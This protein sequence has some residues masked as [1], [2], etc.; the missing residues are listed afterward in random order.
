MH[1]ILRQFAA[2]L[3][4]LQLSSLLLAA[5]P[6]QLT[7]LFPAGGQ[8]GTSVEV[9]ATGKF[10]TWPAKI[11][12]DSPHIE[13]SCLAEAGKLQAKISDQAPAGLQWVRLYDA[14]G[15]TQV[16]PFLID[17]YPQAS[18]T[19]PNDRNDTANAS[20]GLPS[21]FHGV[22]NKTADVDLISVTLA[23]DDWLVATLDSAKW[24]LSPA[25]AC[26]QI[27]DSRGFVL[28]ENLDHVG[29]DPY[30]EYQAPRAGKYFV[31][32]FGFPATPNSTIAFSGG[33]DWIYRLR[34]SDRPDPL[35]TALDIAN[36]KEVSSSCAEIPAAKHTA[37][38]R[39][40]ALSLPAQVTGTVSQP[41]EINY[42]RFTAQAGKTYRVRL[43]ARHFGSPLDASLAILDASGKQL[44]QQDDVAQ[45]RDPLVNWKAPADGDFV[46]AIR[47]FHRQGGAG[48]RYQLKLEE[49]TPDYAAT[50][51]TDLITA[52]VDKEVEV[53]VN[54][55]RELDF[56][57]TI[58]VS[59]KGVPDFVQAPSVESKHGTDTAGKVSLK[60]KASQAFQGPIEILATSTAEPNPE[61][62]AATAGNRPLWLS[63]R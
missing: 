59:L 55:A 9:T 38:D 50:L 19:E 56:P 26:L 2:S 14:A 33:S 53:V 54:I 23:D 18:E 49:R 25:D 34:L 6:P 21:T 29:L 52:D 47:D 20:S 44:V 10:P 61:Q 27:L 24:L 51:A 4:V 17:A 8:I 63:I 48:F 58:S 37:A 42:L 13:W 40:Y 3:A 15:A 32:V 16:F 41:K 57:G 39:A 30:L 36:Q 46:L 60:L 12:S 31:R 35:G 1:P 62:R 11:W 43:W 28:A 7:L 45:D 5:D 22:L